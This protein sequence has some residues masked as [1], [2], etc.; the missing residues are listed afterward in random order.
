[1]AQAVQDPVGVLR[2]LKCQVVPTGWLSVAGGMPAKSYMFQHIN[3][4]VDECLQGAPN[5]FACDI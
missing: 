3:C 4:S 5:V 2:D 1:M